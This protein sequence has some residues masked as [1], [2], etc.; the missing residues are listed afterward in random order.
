[1]PADLGA[2]WGDLAGHY[3]RTNSEKL[4]GVNDGLPTVL[5]F[6]NVFPKEVH[7]PQTPNPDPA[8]LT[9]GC[10]PI[11]IER[12]TDR[13]TDLPRKTIVRRRTE[14]EDRGLVE[15]QNGVEAELKQLL[16]IAQITHDLGGGPAARVRAGSQRGGA[17]VG[18]RLRYLAGRAREGAIGRHELAQANQSS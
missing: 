12:M 15:R 17:S 3:E 2:E 9:L 10:P 13:T 16:D 6:A 4:I 14:G 8:Q 11:R 18:E 5:H 1:M 7:V